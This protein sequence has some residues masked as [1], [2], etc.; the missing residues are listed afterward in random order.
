MT[1]FIPASISLQAFSC[2]HC[3][4]IAH[5]TWF[6]GYARK[7]ENNEPKIISPEKLDNVIKSIQADGGD[8]PTEEVLEYWTKKSEGEV[9]LEPID[10]RYT[11][12]QV[13]NL[14][15]C[16]CFSCKKP[17]LWT[18]EKL[19][20]PFSSEIE[21]ANSDMPP[22]IKVIFD[23]ARMI[24][25]H[26]PRASAALLRL[27]IEKICKHLD[28]EGVTLD[29]KIG[30]LVKKGL[31]EKI[32]KALDSVRVIGNDAV[33]SGQIDLTDGRDISL[34]LFKLVNVITQRMI[35]DV[36]EIDEIY[37]IVPENNKEAIKRRDTPKQSS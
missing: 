13:E 19:I 2:P 1:R 30:S 10:S 8:Q 29:Q 11:N 31:D 26:S 3:G 21:E 17:S 18:H 15:I 12:Y 37:E 24:F 9:F 5:Q 34:K 35:T 36:R 22:N 16:E 6:E 33:H 27:C 4:A 28:A 14:F 32:Q 25:K 20:V 23:E 7:V